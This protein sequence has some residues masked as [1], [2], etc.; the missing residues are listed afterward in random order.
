MTD[1]KTPLKPTRRPRPED[2]RGAAGRAREFADR[3][4]AKYP[5]RRFADSAEIVREDRDTRS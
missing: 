2:V 5:G 4:R 1:R 3:I